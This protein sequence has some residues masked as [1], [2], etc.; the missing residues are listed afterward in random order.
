MCR[1]KKEENNGASPLRSVSGEVFATFASLLLVALV[2][3]CMLQTGLSCAYFAQERKS[4]L[5]AVLDGATA[6]AETYASEG[7][8]VTLPG[9]DNELV[10]RAKTGFE[11]FNTSSD[12]LVFVADRDGNILMHTGK[13]VAESAKIPQNLQEEMDS[14]KDIFLMG[15]MDD[16]LHDKYY[17][18]GRRVN[19]G[20]S[21]GYLFAATPVHA[22]AVYI[23]SILTMFLLSSA[24]IL[25]VCGILCMVLARRITWPIEQISQA[26]KRLGGG[27]F[28]ARAPVTGCQELADFATTFN[29]MAGCKTLITPVG[30]LWAT[31]PMNCA[32]P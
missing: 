1:A 26:A 31:L 19:L 21:E 30:S 29:N 28:T 5:T 16:T 10:E 3:M 23:R 12:A 2:L 18:A 8:I 13:D 9:G 17:I 14:G 32:P 25:I 4:S 6:M 22:L 24:V 27:D 11:L 20:G 15:T 7:N